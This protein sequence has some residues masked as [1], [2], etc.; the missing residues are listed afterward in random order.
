GRLYEI[1]IGSGLVIAG[2]TGLAAW[3]WGRPFLTSA[4]IYISPPILGEMHLASAALFDVGVYVTVVGATMLMIS[5]LGD[6]RHSS[7]AGPV[8]KED[9]S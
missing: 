8:L 2:C 3:L 1:W 5:V 9:V 6:S 4:H 7:M